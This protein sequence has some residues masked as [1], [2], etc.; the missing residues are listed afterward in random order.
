[1]CEE[2]KRRLTGGGNAVLCCLSERFSLRDAELPPHQGDGVGFVAE[3]A[4]QENVSLVE[5]RAH[6]D[7]AGAIRIR[8]FQDSRVPVRAQGISR[9]R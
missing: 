8:R 9:R 1:M 6:P 2:N 4:Q 7:Q 5:V 3:F